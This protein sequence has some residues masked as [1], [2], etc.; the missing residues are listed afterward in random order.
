MIC[1]SSLANH[2]HIPAH[3]KE[4]QSQYRHE[5]LDISSVVETTNISRQCSSDGPSLRLL[6]EFPKS[7][8]IFFTNTIMRNILMQYH[9]NYRI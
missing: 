4:P 8:Q 1:Q 9:K 2:L 7:K 5:L 6:R 3:N